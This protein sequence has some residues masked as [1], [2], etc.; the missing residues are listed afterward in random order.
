METDGDAGQYRTDHGV[1]GACPA[2]GDDVR[3]RDDQC[4]ERRNLHVGHRCEDGPRQRHERHE[5]GARPSAPKQ[6]TAAGLFAVSTRLGRNKYPG[7]RNS[8][9]IDDESLN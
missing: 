3:R 5:D 4:D 7:T 9:D 8:D 2:S 1:S 6:P